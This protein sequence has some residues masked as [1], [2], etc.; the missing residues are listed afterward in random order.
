MHKKAQLLT[1][2]LS[3]PQTPIRKVFHI[4]A[5]IHAPP[6]TPQIQTLIH[7]P[8]HAPILT[9]ITL[10]LNPALPQ[11]HHQTIK[12]TPPPPQTIST[13]NTTN[14]LIPILTPQQTQ[15]QILAGIHLLIRTTTLI[16]MQ[17]LKFM[18]MFMAILILMLILM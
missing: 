12:K 7:I 9:P 13:T 6:R 3:H 2:T 18:A 5:H 1:Q 14:T 16:H 8:N 11:T 15:I 10:A 4:P 17:I